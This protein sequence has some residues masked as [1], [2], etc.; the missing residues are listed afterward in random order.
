[1]KTP[2]TSKPAPSAPNSRHFIGSFP[3]QRNTVTAEV[4]VQLLKGGRISGMDAV[5]A[6]N[7]TRLAAT[8]HSLI[9]VHLWDISH[10]DEKI[11][12]SDGRM[13]EIRIYHLSRQIITAAMQVGGREFC[14]SV[15][16][17]RKSLRSSP[18]PLPTKTKPAG[19]AQ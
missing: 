6:A 7:T 18:Q 15:T 1:M 12:T 10:T 3:K 14:E 16:E 11:Q 2:D 8:I 17:A 5:F 13:T 9:H 19:V 4:L